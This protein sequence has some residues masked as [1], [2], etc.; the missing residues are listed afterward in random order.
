MRR[1][2][3]ITFVGGAVA[4][5]VSWPH[6]V[7]AQQTAMP[8]I[9]YLGV[10]PPVANNLAALR[11]GL[12]EQGYIEGRNVAFEFRDTEQYERLP[13]LAAELV[14]RR[15]AVIFTGSNINAAQ[16]AKAATA[17][18]P[19]VFTVGT[20]PVET[21][22]VTSL[23]RPGGNAS[24]VTYLVEE[25]AP[26]RLELMRELVPQVTTIALLVNPANAQ[27]GQQIR[28]MQTAAGSV[29]QQI[30]VLRASTAS[31]IETAFATLVRE[32]AGGLLINGDAFFV[33]RRDQLLA[34]AS[35]LRIPAVHFDPAFTRAGGLMS[36][37]DDRFESWRQAGVYVGRILKGE[38]P[39]DLPVVQPTRFDFVINLKTAKALGLEFPPSFHL[40]ATEVIE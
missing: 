7:R 38:K 16:A 29:G 30:I 20:N 13:A 21:G 4:A 22:L 9:G 32:R 1:R 14:G 19:I 34:L 33:S 12:S 26:K 27:S 40:R 39:A 28:D 17:T 5:P 10:G 6:A 36:Y 37:S 23:G 35:F 24:G 2:D 25:M 31:E 15:V 3:V 8:V 11:K 18:I